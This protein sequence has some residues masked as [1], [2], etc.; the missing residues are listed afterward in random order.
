ML[1]VFRLSLEKATRK[2]IPQTKE[3]G[4]PYPPVAHPGVNF[5]APEELQ[6][7]LQLCRAAHVLRDTPPPHPM[8]G[9]LFGITDLKIGVPLCSA[10][11]L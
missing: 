5:W 7:H 10:G 8:D 1:S 2:G 4:P 6:L 9:G 11:V 3:R